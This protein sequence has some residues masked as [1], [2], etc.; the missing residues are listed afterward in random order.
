MTRADI[1]LL[2]LT[3]VLLSLRGRSC[4]SWWWA[5]PGSR[6]RSFTAVMDCAAEMPSGRGGG[7]NPRERVIAAVHHDLGR[8]RHIANAGALAPATRPASLRNSSIHST[9][10]A[11]A[12]QSS[13]SPASRPT[14][15]NAF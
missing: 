9:E 5:S 7:V 4:I 13:Q 10:L 11:T 12:A 14:V 2:A 3:A 1:V 8:R 6:L 15:E